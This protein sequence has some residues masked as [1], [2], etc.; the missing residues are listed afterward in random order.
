MKNS[1]VFHPFKGKHHNLPLNI[2]LLK[3]GKSNIKRNMNF[4]VTKLFRKLFPVVIL[5]SCKWKKV[6]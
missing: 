1:V 3:E 2:Y 4:L 6:F 5:L